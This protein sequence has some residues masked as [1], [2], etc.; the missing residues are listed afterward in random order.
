MLTSQCPH[1]DCLETLELPMNLTLFRKEEV[2]SVLTCRPEDEVEL[3]IRFP[4]GNDQQ[5]WLLYAGDNLEQ[6]MSTGLITRINGEKPSMDWKLPKG[7]LP[8]VAEILES[9]DLFTGLIL[10]AECP[11]CG[12]INDIA[13]D[14]EDYL[15]RQ[16]EQQQWQLKRQVH[17]LASIY[18][19]TESEIVA[20]P[21]KRREEYL[22]FIH[23]AMLS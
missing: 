22:Q 8:A 7:W 14:L 21:K 1:E 2:N 15:L 3:E 12:R 4:T 17:Q 11:T 6:E 23:E 9:N 10:Q 20:L 16:L 13:F 5:H 18:H 19:W